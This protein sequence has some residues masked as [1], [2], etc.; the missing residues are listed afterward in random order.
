MAVKPT[1]QAMAAGMQESFGGSMTAL[2]IEQLRAATEAM[3][4]TSPVAV[5]RVV[6]TTVQSGERDVPVRLYWP[7]GDSPPRGVLLWLHGGGFALGGLALGDDLGRRFCEALQLV[8][9]N[10]D[11][12]VAP[13]HPFPAALEDVTAV[14]QWLRS[15]PDVLAGCDSTRV[16]VGGE[17]AGGNLAMVLS[18]RCRDEGLVPPVCQL[19]VYGT[20]ECVISNP[21]LGDLPFLTV[22][23]VEWFWAAYT[24]QRDHPYVSPARAASLQG[25]PPLLMV[26]AEHDPTRDASE[27]YARRMSAEGGR[28]R[29]TRLPGVHH[30]FFGML[31]VLEESRQAFDEAVGFIRASIQEPA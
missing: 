16:G 23:D 20:A 4:P 22:E 17:S 26:T 5:G 24:D 15:A 28:A 12:A 9:V 3:I 7:T 14:Y 6:D 21:E 18:L 10:V 19:S 31:D 13:E 27:S 25:L 30:G 1:V 29:V 8:V 11:Y 2:P